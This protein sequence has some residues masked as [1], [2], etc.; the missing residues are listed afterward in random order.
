MKTAKR[1]SWPLRVGAAL[2]VLLAL[3]IALAMTGWTDIAGMTR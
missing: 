3:I 1:V 2:I